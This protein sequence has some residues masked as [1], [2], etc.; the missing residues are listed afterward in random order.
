MNDIVIGGKGFSLIETLITL[1]IMSILL[2]LATLEFSKWIAKYDIESQ[3]QE[4]YSKLQL[5]RVQAMHRNTCHY[6][7]LERSGYS[8]T[9]DT[10]PFDFGS[11]HPGPDDT[12]VSPF[13]EL[14]YSVDKSATI[15][16]DSRGLVPLNNARTI[17]IPSNANPDFD[18]IVIHRVRIN[19]GKMRRQT[20]E[21][22]ATNCMVK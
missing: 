1:A 19:M 12:V 9:A 5:T 14:K 21:C 13:K 10:A 16:F 15:K 22:I 4:L 18:C 20:D 8:I 17:C 6:F 2:G 7:Q 3:T 11:C